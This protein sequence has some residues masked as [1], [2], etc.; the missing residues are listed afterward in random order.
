VAAAEIAVSIYAFEAEVIPGSLGIRARVR[1]G[2]ERATGCVF[3]F[4]SVSRGVLRSLRQ[5]PPVSP[6]ERP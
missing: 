4:A 1:K 6:G 3:S 2:I 5:R